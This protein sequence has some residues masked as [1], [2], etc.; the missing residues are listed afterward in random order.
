MRRFIPLGL[1]AGV[2][3]SGVGQAW[4]QTPDDVQVVIRE[5]AAT[6]GVPAAPLVALGRCES[7]LDPG[8]VGDS[9]RSHGLFQLNDLPTGL[10]W[11]FLR[12]GYSDAYDVVQAATYVARVASGEWARDGVT[13]RRWSCYR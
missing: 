9:G 2:F 8:A 13:L 1:L 6:Y 5:A 4:G 7:R 12:V 10:L 3:V 11:H